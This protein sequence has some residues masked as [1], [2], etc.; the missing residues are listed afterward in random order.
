MDDYKPRIWFGRAHP[1]KREAI[2]AN[3]GGEFFREG[4]NVQLQQR[5]SGCQGR[6]CDGLM[7]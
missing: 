6:I 4:E 7:I 1:R 5:Q 3:F 2:A